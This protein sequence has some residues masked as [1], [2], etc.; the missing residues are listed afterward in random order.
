MAESQN[1][2]FLGESSESA[3]YTSSIKYQLKRKEEQDQMNI[4]VPWD[5]MEYKEKVTETLI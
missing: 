5:G 1:C 4:H 2:P 3:L